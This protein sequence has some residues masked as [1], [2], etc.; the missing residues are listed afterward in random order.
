MVWSP[1]V[2]RIAREGDGAGVYVVGH[3]L[4]DE[5]LEFVARSGAA[6]HGERVRA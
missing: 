6:E 5:F 1:Q 3:Q 2:R 4:V